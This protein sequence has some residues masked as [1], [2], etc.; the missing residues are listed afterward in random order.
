[1]CQW[2]DDDSS[3]NRPRFEDH[4]TCQQCDSTP[5]PCS[6]IF[7]RIDARPRRRRRLSRSRRILGR[8]PYIPP[9]TRTLPARKI[10]TF[11]YKIL[12]LRHL[13]SHPPCLRLQEYRLLALL[14]AMNIDVKKV[15]PRTRMNFRVRSKA[16]SRQRTREIPGTK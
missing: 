8:R 3:F 9:T 7:A 14:P 4:P 2:L 5:L 16:S 1:M 10:S 12:F 13:L 15:R 6:P 11:L